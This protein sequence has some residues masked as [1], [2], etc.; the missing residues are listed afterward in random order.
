[1]EL[2]DWVNVTIGVSQG[3][4]LYPQL[5]MFSVAD[6]PEKLRFRSHVC[7]RYQDL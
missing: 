3:S 1:M 2:S 5:F 7:Q 4:V 6:I